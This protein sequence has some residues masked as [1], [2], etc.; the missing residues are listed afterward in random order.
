MDTVLKSK[1]SFQSFETNASYNFLERTN[2]M[3]LLRYGGASVFTN[4]GL[5]GT[6]RFSFCESL[7][8]LSTSSSF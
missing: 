8:W 7:N 2:F 1:M 6:R 4:D 5:T 3:W